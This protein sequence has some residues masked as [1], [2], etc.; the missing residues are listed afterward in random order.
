MKQENVQKKNYFFITIKVIYYIALVL[1]SCFSIFAIMFG[2]SAREGAMPQV[3]YWIFP[4]LILSFCY[5]ILVEGLIFT[6]KVLRG[7]NSKV[8]KLLAI[9]PFILLGILWVSGFFNA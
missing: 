4:F 1:L 5:V 8:V 7:S 3:D 6:K 9:F 2:A